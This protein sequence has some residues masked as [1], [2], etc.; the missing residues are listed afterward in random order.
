MLDID[1]QISTVLEID[2]HNKM[3]GDDIVILIS[4]ILQDNFEDSNMSHPP[5]VCQIP[6]IAQSEIM[7][8]RLLRHLS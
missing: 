4:A 6:K 7:P 8:Q 2:G 1:R 3:P 5:L